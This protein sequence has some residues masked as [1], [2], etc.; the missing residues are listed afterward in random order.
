[1]K[2][3]TLHT[4]I[5]VEKILNDEKI[6]F[7]KKFKGLEKSSDI[8][9]LSKYIEQVKENLNKPQVNLA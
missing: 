8:Y 2:Q 9:T 4:T 3:E 1:M 7:I 5:Q 6:K